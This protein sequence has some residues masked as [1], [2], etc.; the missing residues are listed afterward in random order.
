MVLHR[1]KGAFTIILEDTFTN[2]VILNTEILK[3][4]NPESLKGLK[5]KFKTKIPKLCF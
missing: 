1:E 3:D 5:S 2:A 4:K